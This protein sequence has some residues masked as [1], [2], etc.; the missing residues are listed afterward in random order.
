MPFIQLQT[1]RIKLV[2]L[3]ADFALDIL[4][5]N[6][7]N[8]RD[9]FIPFD[10]L[11]NVK[12]WI[13]DTQIKIDSGDKIETVVLA[14]DNEFLGMVA[15]DN[16]NSDTAEIRLWLKLEAQGQ[17]YGKES[18]NL[19]L[20]WYKQEYSN[21]QII[22][23]AEVNNIASVNLAKSLGLKLSREFIDEDGTLSVEFCLL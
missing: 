15:L 9:Y 13:T 19:L 2:P 3:N 17:D 1:A 12:N 5:S 23:V 14:Q 20:D 22:Y 10:N 18:V 21:K 6:R 8:V 11:D 16:L 7:G 4:E